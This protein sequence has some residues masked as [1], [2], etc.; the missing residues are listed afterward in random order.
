MTARNKYGTV[1]IRN[2]N[3]RL[4]L[5]FSYYKRRFQ[6]SLNLVD[7][8]SNIAVA[9]MIAA[10]IELDIATGDFDT[11][12]VKYLGNSKAER[13]KP[14]LTSYSV[15]ASYSLYLDAKGLTGELYKHVE[16]F[17]L[18]SKPDWSSLQRCVEAQGWSVTTHNRYC[19]VLNGFNVWAVERLE[20]PSIVLPLKKGTKQTH[21]TR[22]P[23]TLDEMKAIC[24]AFRNDEFKPKCS[25]YSHSHYYPLVQFLFLTGCRM[26]EIVGLKAKHF[27]LAK[28]TVEIS[29]S[30]SCKS[31][32]DSKRIQKGTKTGSVRV[33]NLPKD[34]SEMISLKLEGKKR[35][36]YVFLGPEGKPVNQKNFT[37]RIWPVV[38][39]GLGLEYRVPY[40]GRHTMASMAIEQGIPLTGIA[41]LM[42]HSDTTMVMKQYGH[43][44]NKPDL[45][46]IDL[47]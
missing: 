42:G 47:G 23:F 10:K 14:A 39:N 15:I 40:A 34:F 36:E 43:M 4:Y 8:E 2:R 25:R 17:L 13:E 33:L 20:K 11:T 30:L 35:D 28:G 44:I 27:D 18:R 16:R 1:K 3:G 12:L 32:Y 6:P 19:K 21:K 29:E 41:Y 31:A 22:K 46:T 9:K 5:E 7:C 37:T 38:L 24:N 26:G 45:P